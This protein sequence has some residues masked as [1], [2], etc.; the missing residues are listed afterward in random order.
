[1]DHRDLQKFQSRIPCQC[2]RQVRYHA[3]Q[4]QLTSIQCPTDDAGGALA[5]KSGSRRTGCSTPWNLVLLKLTDG[6]IGPS[7]LVAQ[8]LSKKWQSDVVDNDG[9]PR[10]ALGKARRARSRLVV[11][12]ARL[13]A[14]G[15]GLLPNCLRWAGKS[16]AILNADSFPQ[17]LPR[18]FLRRPVDVACGM[19][20]ILFPACGFDPS[21]RLRTGPTPGSTRAR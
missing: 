3:Y 2:C 13:C 6:R 7:R 1:V 11:L 18:L 8:C 20:P 12:E 5:V 16:P 19:L 4:Y 14:Q 10:V 9:Q 15:D 21:T 17:P